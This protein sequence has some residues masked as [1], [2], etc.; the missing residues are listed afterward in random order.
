MTHSEGWQRASQLPSMMMPPTQLAVPPSPSDAAP[1][2]RGASAGESPLASPGELSAA[3]PVSTVEVSAG[4]SEPPPSGPAPPPDDELEEEH[5][6]ATARVMAPIH[7]T[8][9]ATELAGCTVL[10]CHFVGAGRSSRMRRAYGVAAAWLALASAAVAAGACGGG[11]SG[12]SAGGG[13]DG[14]TAADTFAPQGEA[15]SDSGGGLESGA[16]STD[17]ALDTGT[18]LDQTAPPFDSGQGQPPNMNEPYPPGPYGVGA[19]STIANMHFFGFPAPQTSTNA[20]VIQLA[21][22]YN[23]S[24]HG[25]LPA[26]SPYGSGP[27]PL[28]LVIDIGAVWCPNCT[29]EA[30]YDLPWRHAA[31]QPAGQILSLLLDGTTMGTPATLKNLQNWDKAFSVDYPSALDPGYEAL[32]LVPADAFPGNVLVRTT[33]MRIMFVSNGIPDAPFWEAVQALLPGDA[34][35][36]GDAWPE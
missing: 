7:A 24:G 36:V 13:S 31:M 33:D 10:E 3:E 12:S 20:V 27:L 26:G 25:M 28:A 9:V 16:G 14:S 11:T 30:K 15:G 29:Q 8:E 5:P 21:D 17:S 18:G 22:F 2:S 1:E 32:Q 23:P 4:A 6:A 34:G 19:G 35:L